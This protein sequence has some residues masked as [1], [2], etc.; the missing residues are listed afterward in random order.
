MGFPRNVGIIAASKK[1]SMTRR[2]RR[3]HGPAFKTKVAVSAIRG[4]R[5]LI[6]LAQDFEVLP[7]QIKEWRDLLP[8]G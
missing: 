2:L 7:N 4:E 3:N 8:G 5:I 6:E 1:M